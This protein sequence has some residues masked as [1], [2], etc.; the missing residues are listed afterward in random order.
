[1]RW[2]N[3]FIWNCFRHLNHCWLQIT[4]MSS[5]HTWSGYS[6]ATTLNPRRC[7]APCW[8]DWNCLSAGGSFLSFLGRK[9]L[10]PLFV[11]LMVHPLKIRRTCRTLWRSDPGSSNKGLCTL[12]EDQV[13]KK[14]FISQ[15]PHSAT[16]VLIDALRPNQSILQILCQVVEFY[17]GVL[18]SC[19]GIKVWDVKKKVGIL[20]EGS[21]KFTIS[22]FDFFLWIF[23]FFT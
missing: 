17:D 1:M 9:S 21:H 20:R 10:K 3:S 6:S 5:A 13:V 8:G 15:R 4:V 12:W 18:G 2:D 23:N 11:G 22:H 7:L 19:W 14:H 16:W